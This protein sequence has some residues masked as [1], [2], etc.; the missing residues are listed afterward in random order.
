MAD[1]SS[2][3]NSWLVYPVSKT[4]E[5]KTLRTDLDSG[6]LGIRRQKWQNPRYLFRLTVW[7]KSQTDADAF[8]SFFNA[9]KGG[10]EAF[11]WTPPAE[12][13]GGP[14]TCIFPEDRLEMS[15]EGP[16]R[17]VYTF[18]MLGTA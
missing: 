9:R 8:L 18:T 4:E 17:R 16:E 13:G 6:G 2:V 14:Y 7:Y 3:I 12:I 10:R 5:W 15:I 11:T 1:I